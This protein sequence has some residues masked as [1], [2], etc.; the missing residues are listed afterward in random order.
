M[1]RKINTT[2]TATATTKSENQKSTKCQLN[3][4]NFNRWTKNKRRFS[5]AIVSIEQALFNTLVTCS[6]LSN[7]FWFSFAIFI[8]LLFFFGCSFRCF[9]LYKRRQCIL[10][11][12]LK[13][14]IYQKTLLPEN[15]MLKSHFTMRM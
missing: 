4:Y 9:F 15:T 13:S 11:I 8:Y 2:A 5:T 10:I 7:L 12:H 14:G 1:A 6:F 3:W